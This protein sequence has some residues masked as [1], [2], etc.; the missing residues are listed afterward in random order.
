[1]IELELKNITDWKIASKSKNIVAKPLVSIMVDNK[2]LN[3]FLLDTLEGKESLGN[4]SMVCVGEAGDAWQQ[5][6][7]KLLAKYKVISID[8]DGWL[9]C[10]P[11]PGNASNCKEITKD[12]IQQFDTLNILLTYPSP[13]LYITAE[14]GEQLG[15]KSIQRCEIGD[16]ILCDRDNLNDVWV[17]KRKIFLNT[18]IIKN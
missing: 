14:W 16:F 5:M 13:S 8:T 1:M 11:L 3:K 6:P 18:Y 4:G 9:V 2:I 10:E 7:N 12:F 15:D 17:V